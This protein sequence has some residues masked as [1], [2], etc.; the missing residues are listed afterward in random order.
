[1]AT[2]K[3]HGRADH[4]SRASKLFPT[5]R[6]YE[7]T[8]NYFEKEENKNARNREE[9]AGEKGKK[10]KHLYHQTLSLAEKDTLTSK[11]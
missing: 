8:S 3:I 11:H 2:V 5:L 4:W 6:C 9:G 7:W 10:G 1:M